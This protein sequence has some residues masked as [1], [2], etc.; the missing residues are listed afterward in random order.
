MLPSTSTSRGALYATMDGT[1]TMH[2]W[3]VANWASREQSRHLDC[4]ILPKT[5]STTTGT[6][7]W[8]ARAWRTGSRTA[9]ILGW[10][11]QVVSQGKRLASDARVSASYSNGNVGMV[12]LGIYVLY[13]NEFDCFIHLHLQL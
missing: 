10:V 4:H 9:P 11:S 1:S 13:A 3:Y 8:S 12:L 7:T 5:Y 6:R 2:T